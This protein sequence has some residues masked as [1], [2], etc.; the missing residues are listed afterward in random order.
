MKIRW[1]T[2]EIL[3]A[4]HRRSLNDH[5]G[6]EGVADEAMLESAIAKPQNLMAYGNPSIFELAAGYATG[7]VKNHAFI[8]GNKRTAFLAAYIFL[9]LNGYEL[10]ADEAE[11]AAITLDLA[12]SAVSETEF[13]E[14]LK[15]NSTKL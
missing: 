3:L 9:G 12:A 8:D 14:W 15:L 13:A 2:K 10:D 6:A 5:G 11:A 7:V 4:A 1:L